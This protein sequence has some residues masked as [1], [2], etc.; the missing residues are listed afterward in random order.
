MQK[1][2]ISLIVAAT[3]CGCVHTSGVSSVNIADE[4]VFDL[5]PPAS[6]GASL[7]LTQ[8]A[9]LE[10][11]DESH[12]LLFYTEVT[13]EHISLVGVLPNG[14]RLFS[15]IYDGHV[16]ESDGNQDLLGKIAPQYF[17]ADLQLAQWPFMQ[18]AATLAG[19]N[20][21][22]GSGECEF[23]ESLDHLQRSLRRDGQTI[24]DV[25]YQEFPHYQGS[26]VYQHRERAYRLQVETLEIQG[27]EVQSTGIAKPE[28]QQP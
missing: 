18:V 19:S 25:Q 12:E 14:T 5:L 22:F 23:A 11:G 24:I 3:L 7:L 13:Q 8:A 4:L 26:T 2:V 15:I 16:I 9:T 17:L 20:A 28:A 6:F 10:F 21:C 1:R 27:G